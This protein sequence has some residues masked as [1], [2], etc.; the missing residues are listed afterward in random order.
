MNKQ[1]NSDHCFICGVKNVAGA[2][3]A[4]YEVEAEDGAPELLARFTGRDVHQG[5]PGRM[6]GGVI[7]GILDEVMSRCITYGDAALNPPVWGVTVEM[8]L[9]YQAPV[10]LG[11]ELNARGRMTRDRSRTAE[12]SA[13]LYL[14]DGTVAVTATGKYMKLPLDRIAEGATDAL[15]WRVYADEG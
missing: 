1:P 10:P 2:Q 12:A 9:R 4:F 5:Y 15:N 8:A 14:P 7:A 11:V 6:H 3:V 13:E